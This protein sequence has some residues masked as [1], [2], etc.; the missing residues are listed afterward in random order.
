MNERIQKLR[1]QSLHTSPYISPER[2][3][4]VTEFYQSDQAQGVSAAVRRALAFA[5]ILKSKKICI[6]EGELI[7]GE[8]GPAPQATPTYP[9]ICIHSLD[10]LDIIH[11]REKVSFSVDEETRKTYSDTIIP[12][13]SGKSMREKIFNEMSKEWKQYVL[14]LC[15][16]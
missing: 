15:H 9:E 11:S 14:N 2:A 3:M 6:N 13:W 12:Y 4:L 7:V 10:D 5:H 16:L 8:R 1:E